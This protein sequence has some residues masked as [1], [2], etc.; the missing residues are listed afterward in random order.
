MIKI[1]YVMCLPA[2]GICL[3]QLPIIYP[4]QTGI[5]WVTPS[6]E[7]KSSPVKLSF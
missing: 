5:A 1:T 2:R 4:S 7:S 6:P 3:I